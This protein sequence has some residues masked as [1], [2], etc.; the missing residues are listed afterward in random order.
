M[1]D[2]N[3][4]SQYAGTKYTNAF[5][6]GG[7]TLELFIASWNSVSEHSSKQLSVTKTNSYGQSTGSL[8]NGYLGTS[9]S[10]WMIYNRNKTTG[11][12]LSSPSTSGT[13]MVSGIDCNGYVF[14]MTAHGESGFRPV[15]CIPKN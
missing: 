7:P 15:V 1:M 5:A 13:T 9:D 11:Y 3:K 6:I 10:M 12:W 8:G 14:T 4:W 2:K